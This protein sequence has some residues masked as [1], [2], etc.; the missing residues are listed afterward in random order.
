MSVAIALIGD[1]EVVYLDEPT[2]GMDPINR[3]HVWDVIEAAK[4]D[5]AVILTTH[6]MEEADALG[7]CVGIM[8]KGKLRCI[9]S[10]VRLKSR[11]GAGYKVR[12][13]LMCDV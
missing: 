8:A 13:V 9:G 4:Q 2:T 10:T 7:D 12:D 3:R 6:N 11:F 1:P 5:R